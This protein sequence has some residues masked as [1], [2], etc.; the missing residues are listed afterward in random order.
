[1]QAVLLADFVDFYN[2]RVLELGDRLGLAAESFNMFRIPRQFGRQ[3][4][5]RDF[6]PVGV[7]RE[8]YYPHPA[9]ADFLQKRVFADLFFQVCLR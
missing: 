3:Y 9:L 7:L 2:M 6:L 1:M 4:L 5:Q 8:V